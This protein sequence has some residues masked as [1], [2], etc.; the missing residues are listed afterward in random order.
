MVTNLLR[1][2]AFAVIYIFLIWIYVIIFQILV[3]GFSKS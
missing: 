3:Y 2:Y 1:A